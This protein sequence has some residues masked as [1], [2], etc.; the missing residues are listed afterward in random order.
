MSDLLIVSGFILM[1]L[2]P[3]LI[4]LQTAWKER[5][6]RLAG[7]QT[8]VFPLDARASAILAETIR[9]TAVRSSRR[10]SRAAAAMPVHVVVR[11][12]PQP[13]FALPGMAP[14]VRR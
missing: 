11:V 14:V 13:R 8:P 5:R 3:C 9:P 12:A 7:A 4:A 10:Q 1:V 2:A 6:E